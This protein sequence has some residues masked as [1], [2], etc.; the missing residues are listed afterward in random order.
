MASAVLVHRIILRPESRLRKVTSASVVQ[1]VV[2]LA[3]V[4]VPTADNTHGEAGWS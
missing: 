4:P 2:D 3:P 1:E